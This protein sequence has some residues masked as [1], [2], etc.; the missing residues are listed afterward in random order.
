MAT[1]KLGRWGWNGL[2][3]ASRSMSHMLEHRLFDFP[4]CPIQTRIPE[5]IRNSRGLQISTV[6]ERRQGGRIRVCAHRDVALVEQRLA[7]LLVGKCRT[8]RPVI[9]GRVYLG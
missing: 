4:E 9:A 1:Y 8:R 2:S 5:R 7:D 6:A 3:A